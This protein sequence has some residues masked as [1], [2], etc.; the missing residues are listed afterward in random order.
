MGNQLVM[1]VGLISRNSIL[2]NTIHPH[3]SQN[4]DTTYLNKFDILRQ[5]GHDLAQQV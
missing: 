4:K 2:K 3:I 1:K 5:E